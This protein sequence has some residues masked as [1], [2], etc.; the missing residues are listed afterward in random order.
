[1]VG[2]G[3]GGSPTTRPSPQRAVRRNQGSRSETDVVD[4]VDGL[5]VREPLA[6][7]RLQLV[8][9][10]RAA[11]VH[12]LQVGLRGPDGLLVPA[13]PDVVD[14]VGRHR[15]AEALAVLGV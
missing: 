13:D 8:D 1:A 6:V 2:A 9:Q 14:G 3:W 11:E 5:G 4:A 12:D 10:T 7:G 15:L